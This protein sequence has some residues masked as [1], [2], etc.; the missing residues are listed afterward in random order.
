MNTTN[1]DTTEAHTEGKKASL[2]G[3]KLFLLVVA[4]IIATSVLTV[5]L[6][7]VYLFPKQFKPVELSQRE[8]QA[9][10][11]KLESLDPTTRRSSPV[12]ANGESGDGE[13]LKPQ[14]YSEEGASRN[15]NFSERELNALLAKNTDLAEKL[16]VDLSDDLASARLILPLDPDF[17][18]LGGKTLKL[19][20]GLELRYEDARPVIMLRGVSLW[21][22]PVPNAW[23]GGL[24][25]VDVVKEFGGE[26]GFWKAFADGIE[27]I[28]VEDGKLAV[29]LKE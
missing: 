16:A 5:W 17:P 24:K 11:A 20:A 13:A 19:N 2:G 7:S 28:R 27:Y 14:K 23:L 22:V 18:F 21:G 3:M 9:L 15:V 10:S 8:S 1:I 6:M 29:Q 25:N 26:R 12:N 4:V